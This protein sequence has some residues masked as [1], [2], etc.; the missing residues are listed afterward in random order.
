M[1]EPLQMPER[2]ADDGP[3]SIR[4]EGTLIFIEH[5]GEAIAFGEYNA[6]RLF[7][8]LALMLGIPVGARILRA[9][10]L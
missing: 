2:T 4:R 6:W 7:G 5:E 9:I 10:K 3:L 1:T 8:M